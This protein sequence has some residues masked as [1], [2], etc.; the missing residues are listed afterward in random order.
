MDSL[1]AAHK[2]S[3]TLQKI[4]DSYSDSFEAQLNNFTTK[5]G[6]DTTTTDTTTTDTNI[7]TNLTVNDTGTDNEQ[8]RSKN[9]FF[10]V[11][12]FVVS[13]KFDSFRGQMRKELLEVVDP[14]DKSLDLV[15]PGLVTWH[16]SHQD[17]FVRLRSEVVNL[18]EMVVTKIDHLS[19][20]TKMDSLKAA[21]KLSLTLQKLSDSYSDSFEAQLND[22]TTKMGT[23]TT[24]TTDTDI[25]TTNLTVNDTETDNEQD[26]SNTTSIFLEE[27]NQERN[28]EQREREI[29]QATTTMCSKHRCLQDVWNEWYGLDSFYDIYG[30]IKGREKTFGTAW[31]KGVV[32]NH[33]FSRTKRSIGG[34]RQFCRDNKLDP[35]EAI[36]L[37]EDTFIE[38]KFSIYNFLM[39]LQSKGLVKTKRSRGKNIK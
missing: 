6:K 7:T 11:L 20:E 13:N 39:K 27:E 18:K 36:A 21:H 19:K 38:S 28:K 10:Q 9:P 35:K 24:T 12:P 16:R 37:L 33:H 34:I 23:D 26:R 32:T 30:G 25:T 22:F 17:A 1:K 4:S 31:R 14:M 5:M 2:L 3:M 29:R 15:V 8:D